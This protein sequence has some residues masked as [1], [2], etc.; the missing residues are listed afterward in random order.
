VG[1]ECCLGGSIGGGN[2]A[3]QECATYGTTCTNG[4][5]ADASTN[6]QAIA[7]ACNQVS[8]CVAN[9]KTGATACC[10]QG[11]KCTSGYTCTGSPGA[12]PYPKY[13]DGVAIVCEGTGGGTTATAC[14]AGETQVCSSQAD[15]P[16]GTT[17]TPGKWKL[18]QLGFCQ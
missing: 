9:G 16:T 13:S 10:L 18:Y 5:G 17:C 6:E 14:A 8:D 1:Q 4:G 12:C 7:I 11:A 2:F 15:C 3:P